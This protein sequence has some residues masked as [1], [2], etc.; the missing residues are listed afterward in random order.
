MKKYFLFIIFIL[1]S[2]Y[3]FYPKE[4]EELPRIVIIELKSAVDDA[5][6]Y[7]NVATEMLINGF[8]SSNKFIVVEKNQINKVFEELKLKLTDNFN[9]YQVMEIGKL[10]KANIIVFGNISKL[11]S[12]INMNVRVINV[13]LEEDI[14]IKNMNTTNE[15]ELYEQVKKLVDSISSLKIEKIEKETYAFRKGFDF[16]IG[17]GV[18][19]LRVQGTYYPIS[20]SFGYFSWGILLPIS[21]TYFFY[22]GYSF[23]FIFK[24]GYATG[25]TWQTSNFMV[26][27]HSILFNISFKNKFGNPDKNFRY[28]LEYGLFLDI[29]IPTSIINI[30]SLDSDIAIDI[31]NDFGNLYL[32][33]GVETLI[34]FEYR[35][36]N[37]SIESG[38]F[39]G[40]AKSFQDKYPTRISN[41]SYKGGFEVRFNYYFYN[42]YYKKIKM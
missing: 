2:E 7:A 15:N 31:R 1:F 24:T 13:E 25:F 4:I 17:G 6:N 19:P 39:L 16:T 23:G 12:Q 37:F 30:G 42:Y 29:D 26:D 41:M 11:G 32:E 10:C 8:M 20:N 33:L 3:L 5:K 34:G 9:D 28:L 22:P 35:I 38:F 18:Y 27:I 40:V 21:F 36:K 14:Y